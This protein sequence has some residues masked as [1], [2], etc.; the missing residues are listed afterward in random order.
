MPFG[1]GSAGFS[2]VGAGS[3]PAV[4]EA[5][6]SSA[7]ARGDASDAAEAGDDPPGG[8]DAGEEATGA[9]DP[10]AAGAGAVTSA[11]AAP[12]PERRSD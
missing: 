4:T 6:A 12:V 1:P 11:G 9:D 3:E 10:G 8:A 7:F 5:T 2:G